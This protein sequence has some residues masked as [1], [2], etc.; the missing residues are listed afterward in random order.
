MTPI[1]RTTARDRGQASVEFALALPLVAILVLG[2]VQLVVVARDQLAVEL[3][4]RDGARAAAVSAAPDGAARRA[5]ELAVSLRP[6]SVTTSTSGERV[7]V[8]VTH[9]SPTE[10]PIIGA[11]LGDV[12]VTGRAAM[13]REPP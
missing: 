13:V 12:E 2:I 3:A 10:V 1:L 6:L 9:R 8:T 5:A 11:L 7:E 4:A